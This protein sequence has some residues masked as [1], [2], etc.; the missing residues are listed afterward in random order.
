MTEDKLKQI[1]EI[2]KLYAKPKT[3]KIPLEP[4]EGEIQVEIKI[5]PLDLDQVDLL[6]DNDLEDKGDSTEKVFEL[7]AVSL[8]TDT[9]TVKKL[10]LEY[11]LDLTQIIRKAN[12]MT[13]EQIEKAGMK[14][15]IE[16]QQKKLAEA[17]EKKKQLAKGKET[18]KDEPS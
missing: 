11:I 10:S 3:Y 7:L 4:K 15:F 14:D 5:I 16:K 13:D 2:R 12:N 18:K 17:K 1:D 8:G 9:A 6:D